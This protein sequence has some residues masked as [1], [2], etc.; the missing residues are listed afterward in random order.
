MVALKAHRDLNLC[1]RY[2]LPYDEN[3]ISDPNNVGAIARSETD[4]RENM[5]LT[6]RSPIET[7]YPSSC[8]CQ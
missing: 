5:K 3:N 6:N 1:Y 7:H 8:L 2:G 4:G